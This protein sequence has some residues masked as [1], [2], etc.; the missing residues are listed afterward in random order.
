MSIN[1]RSVL[2][3]PAALSIPS[4]GQAA[5]A[6][7][8]RPIALLRRLDAVGASFNAIE[9]KPGWFDVRIPASVIGVPMRF[10]I[11]TDPAFHCDPELARLIEQRLAAEIR[12]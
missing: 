2:A 6:R 1:R 10:G 11:C 7:A 3:I 12:S 5:S 9:G 4:E 8:S